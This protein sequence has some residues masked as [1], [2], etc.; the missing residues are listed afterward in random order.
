MEVRLYLH[1][2]MS[3]GKRSFAPVAYGKNSKILPQRALIGG[4]IE[5]HPE[6]QY[7]LRYS[8]DG[9]Q[10]F[11]P[12]GKDAEVAVVARLRK[13]HLLRA[14]A[15]GAN[16]AAD[17]VGD[18]LTLAKAKERFLAEK[19]AH[20]TDKTCQEF[21][22]VLPQF[23]GVTGKRYL[24]EINSEDLLGFITHLRGLGL[25]DRTVANKL[26]RIECFLRRFGVVNLLTRYE[27]QRYV[28]KV[29]RAYSAAEIQ[30]LIVASPQHERLLWH[31]FVGTGARETEVATACWRDIDFGRQTFKVQEKPEYKYKPKD[32]EQRL[33]PLHDGLIE[34]L[35]RRREECPRDT[36]IFPNFANLPPTHL[37]RQLKRRALHGGLACG[38]C[39]SSSGQSCAKKPICEYW[40]LHQFRR[41]YATLHSESGVSPRT[42]QS[43]LGHSDLHTTLRYLATADISSQRTRTMVN[44]SFATLMQTD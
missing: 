24:D 14:A 12:V 35:R 6:G 25:K 29:A 5:L 7:Y 31:F 15:L 27:R 17:G 39:R 26:A 38:Y 16:V 11:R 10:V 43:W 19:A 18:R 8:L 40:T 3:S 42:I 37:L 21:T 28:K 9:K 44:Q 41:S 20:R 2:K 13:E 36:L 34:M 1:I 30:K 33:V 22:Y 23:I 4:Q 32:F